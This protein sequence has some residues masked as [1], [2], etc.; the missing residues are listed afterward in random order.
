METNEKKIIV[1]VDDTLKMAK[2]AIEFINQLKVQG[3]TPTAEQY[4]VA[5]NEMQPVVEAAKVA[6]LPECHYDMTDAIK[7]MENNC[8]PAIIGDYIT[9]AQTRLLNLLTFMD[10]DLL[11]L[12][13]GH[14]II[15]DVININATL[16]ICL[17]VFSCME[18]KNED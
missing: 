13:D 8:P 16:K 7:Y 4:E 1:N 6:D 12:P 5:F 11:R 9:D 15:D 14:E 18:I 3:K 17:N 2:T 10:R